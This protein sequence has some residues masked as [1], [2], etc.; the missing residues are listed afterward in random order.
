MCIQ[1]YGVTND[2]FVF[3]YC[4]Q[5]SK[6]QSHDLI[7]IIIK[8]VYGREKIHLETNKNLAFFNKATAS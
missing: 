5:G 7:E 1:A 4:F 2:Y 8:K 6:A 3:T